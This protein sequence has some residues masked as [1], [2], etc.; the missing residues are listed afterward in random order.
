MDNCWLDPR[1]NFTEIAIKIKQFWY[2][3]IHLKMSSAKYRPGCLGLAVLIS[4]NCH[5]V[6]I[7]LSPTKY[8]LSC[9]LTLYT[10]IFLFIFFIC[11]KN[12]YLCFH[13]SSRLK[14]YRYMLLYFFSCVESKYQLTVRVHREIHGWRKDPLN[15]CRNNNVVITSKRRHLT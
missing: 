9:F 11:W 7:S 4:A 15:T 14:W 6:L 3:K 12:I 10:L 1:I 8:W 2:V 5:Y 13:H